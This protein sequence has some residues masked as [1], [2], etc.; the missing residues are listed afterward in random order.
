MSVL[1]VDLWLEQQLEVLLM[2]QIRQEQWSQDPFHQYYE[3]EK[4]IVNRFHM[5]DL[6]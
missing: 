1:V 2:D 5:K 6:I 3:L 4:M